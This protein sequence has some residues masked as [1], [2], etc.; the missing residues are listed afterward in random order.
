MKKP[1]WHRL[2]LVLSLC[3][4][5][6]CLCCALVLA[7]CT[8]YVAARIDYTGD[9]LLFSAARRGSMTHFYVNA[10]G[11]CDD[12][13][14]YRPVEYRIEA[15]GGEEKLWYSYD[16]ISED[17][18]NA[19]LA[20]EDRKFFSHHGVDWVRTARAALNR[21]TRRRPLYGAS[22]ITQQVVKN[23]SGDREITLRRKLTELLRARHLE[24]KY[25]KEE[26][27]EVY[28]NIVPMGDKLVGIGAAARSYF[29]KEPSEL[30]LAEAATLVGVTN[31]PARYHPRRHPEAAIEKRDRVLAS[32]ADFGMID[33]ALC[34][35][36][37]E[38]PL[39]LTEDADAEERIP[40]WFTETV[41]D[42]VCEDL[43]KEL[44]MGEESARKL[45]STGGLSIYTTLRPE[46]QEILEDRF[47]NMSGLPQGLHYAMVVT[48]SA[49]DTLVGIVG[50]VGKKDGARLL[51][52]ALAPH[53]PGSA[54]KPL[55]LYAP[56]LNEKRVNAATVFDD[57]PLSFIQ[58]EDGL[59]EY[60]R[61]A[62]NVYQG[63]I[64]LSDALRLSKNTVALR[65]YE[66]RGAER[67]YTSLREDLYLDGLVRTAQTEDGRVLTDLA[68]APLALGQLTRGISLRRLTEAY[69]VFPAEGI[70]RRGRSYLA[71][72]D[73]DGRLLLENKKNEARVFSAECAR[74]MNRML[75]RVV[76]DGTARGITLGEIV[77]T[78]GKTGT[79]GESRDRIFVGYTPYYTAGIWCGYA[80][81]HS[82][83]PSE[84]PSHLAVWD[85]V[86]RRVHAA[87]LADVAEEDTRRFSAEGLLK[88]EFCMD[89]GELFSDACLLDLRSS[90][91]ASAYFTEDNRPK[92][93]CRTH[94][95]LPYDR[96]T[97]AVACGSCPAEWVV[98]IA[99]IR[100]P[101][102]SFP[103]E[104]TV[105]DAQ[106]VYR[107]EGAA[108]P[109]RGDSYDIPY[110]Y[111]MLPPEEYCGRSEGKKQYNSYCY[112]HDG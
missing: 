37:Q 10:D 13:R 74:I 98:P 48:D 56:L 26:I 29:G 87:C 47:E 97:M 112:L 100:V 89:S 15:L 99:L 38:M 11:A 72:F 55:A 23:I 9:E 65:L 25:S 28:L 36:T 62:P 70:M 92:E 67:I 68:P 49:T 86:M 3:L 30:T 42:D 58:T 93:P 19:F 83:V 20:V 4:L 33:E 39:S 110:F 46:V 61:N 108:L 52:Y 40:S 18:K 59:R 32:M 21:L 81:G 82:S 104:V 7:A 101:T 84:A 85:D 71:V 102:R 1:L 109:R 53:A 31:A 5:A 107:G 88:C 51:N 95:V 57:V 6:V 34:R 17:V 80:D 60:P 78:A 35:R 14:A 24:K 77:D 43:Q 54:L 50:N 22:T 111:Y 8:A 66:M 41:L 16:E 12:V 79:S 44:G 63:L 90:R 73:A 91:A 45:L 94:V 75:S 2:L 27:F 96:M 103:K 64:T 76:E 106:Y 69:S 105:T